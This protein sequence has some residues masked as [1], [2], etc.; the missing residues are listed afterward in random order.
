MPAMAEIVLSTP[1]PPPVITVA[2][3]PPSQVTAPIAQS[4]PRE[5]G[6]APAPSPPPISAPDRK[7]FAAK[8]FG[9]L[10]RYKRY[11]AVARARRTE[12]VVSVR[13]TMD[14]KGRVLS[15]EIAKTSGAN[16]RLWEDA[17]T[18]YVTAHMALAALVH[19]K[20]P[21]VV[22]QAKKLLADANHKA[23]VAGATTK[24]S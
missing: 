16:Q 22:D 17:A 9:H 23:D 20:T 8:L 14:R 15:F 18:A 2:P 3:A 4:T 21:T 12:G 10:N 13:F 1:P 11:P 5:I 6:R 7:A 19:V 24:R